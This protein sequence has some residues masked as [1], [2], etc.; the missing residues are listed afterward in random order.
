MNIYIYTKV[1]TGGDFG[2]LLLGK[3]LGEGEE[4][5]DACFRFNYILIS[6]MNGKKMVALVYKYQFSDL[7]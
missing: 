3:N 4:V 1:F 5:G 7:S 2:P 6:D